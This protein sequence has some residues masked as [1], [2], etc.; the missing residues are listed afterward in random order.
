MEC[1]ILL[2]LLY[3][4]VENVSFNLIR[5]ILFRSVSIFFSSFFCFPIYA[6][7]ISLIFDWK[8]D[9][10][11]IYKRNRLKFNKSSCC[12]ALKCA[13]NY[14]M[15][16]IQFISY[17]WLKRENDKEMSAVRIERTRAS[18]RIFIE[19]FKRNDYVAKT[20]IVLCAGQSKKKT[21]SEEWTEKKSAHNNYNNNNIST[22]AVSNCLNIG[23]NT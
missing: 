4:S 3:L 14:L 20:C 2:L 6:H 13:L 10:T 7:W 19:K 15:W 11:F 21:H 9:K 17:R 18:N 12:H 1:F 16:L 5:S 22:T 23:G 8:C